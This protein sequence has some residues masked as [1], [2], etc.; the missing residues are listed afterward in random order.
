[1]PND[2]AALVALADNCGVDATLMN[3]VML[4]NSIYRSVGQEVK[5]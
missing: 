3:A 4:K 2:V 1:M 5:Q